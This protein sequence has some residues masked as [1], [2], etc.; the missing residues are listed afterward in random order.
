MDRRSFI[1]VIALVVTF[2]FVNQWFS[3]KSKPS[4]SVPPSK[5]IET[6]KEEFNAPMNSLSF[7]ATPMPSGEEYFVLENTYQQIVFSNIGGSIAEI[8]LPFQSGENRKSFVRP[9]HIDKIFFEKYS[10]ND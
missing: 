8:N 4:P 7:P 9:I 3:S 10:S 5:K 2:F 1:F 6:L